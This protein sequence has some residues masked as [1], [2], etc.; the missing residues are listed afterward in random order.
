M[1]KEFK[2]GAVVMNDENM[3]LC[4]TNGRDL[5]WEN[6]TEH[7]ICFKDNKDAEDFLNKWNRNNPNAILNGVR[8]TASNC[9]C[10][11][12]RR[13]VGTTSARS[14]RTNNVTVTPEILALAV[15]A[16]KGHMSDFAKVA[17]AANKLAELEEEKAEIEESLKEVNAEIKEIKD[18][19]KATKREIDGILGRVLSPQMVEAVKAE[20]FGK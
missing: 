11:E 2:N 15:S 3:F 4:T 6:S 12:E 17:E 18:S 10:G 20:L 8:I 9:Q 7:A 13:P 1:A 14:T 19:M 16:L 5:F